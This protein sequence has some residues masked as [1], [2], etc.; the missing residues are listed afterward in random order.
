MR[1]SKKKKKEITLKYAELMHSVANDDY[2]KIDLSNRTNTYT[3][4]NGHTIET[5]DIDAGCTPFM[6]Q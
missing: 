2:Y 5:I 1:H 4:P 3:C 6:H